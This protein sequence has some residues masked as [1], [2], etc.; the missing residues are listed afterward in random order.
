MLASKLAKES[1][2]LFEDDEVTIM[3]KT[4]YDPK[5]KKDEN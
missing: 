5:V 2:I 3:T 4:L 1:A